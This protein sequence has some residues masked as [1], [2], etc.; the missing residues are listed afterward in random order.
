MRWASSTPSEMNVAGS[1][2]SPQ[3]RYLRWISRAEQG[4]REIYRKW[5]GSVRLCPDLWRD[6]CIFGQEV[7]PIV[8]DYRAIGAF[9][10]KSRVYCGTICHSELCF[11]VHSRFI[12]HS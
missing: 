12:L 6:P 9:R 7:R 4:G 10:V 2:P 8:A 1:E 5:S 11:H 3:E